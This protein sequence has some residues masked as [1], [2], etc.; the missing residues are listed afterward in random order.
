VREGRIKKGDL[1]LMVAIGGGLHW[2]ATLLR[3]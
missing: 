2:G 1:V 3:A